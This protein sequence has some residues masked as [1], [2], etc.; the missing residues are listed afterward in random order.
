[1]IANEHDSGKSTKA[2]WN[3]LKAE[4]IRGPHPHLERAMLGVKS[5]V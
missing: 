2:R 4:T 1:M 3:E 5:Q